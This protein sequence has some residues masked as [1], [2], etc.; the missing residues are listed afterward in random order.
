MFILFTRIFV[1]IGKFWNFLQF[2]CG[3]H[4]A[5]VWFLTLFNKQNQISA[6]QG[7]LNIS[8]KKR[9]FSKQEKHVSWINN[10]EYYFLSFYKVIG[11]YYDG[12][13][14]EYIAL[15]IFNLV[16]SSDL[17]FTFQCVINYPFIYENNRLNKSRSF[18]KS[19][20]M[21]K[22]HLKQ[23]FRKPKRYRIIQS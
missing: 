8:A 10:F 14:T 15:N 3:G 1:S 22:T 18:L 13:Y 5:W 17:A 4:F 21:S 16:Y 12:C 19:N 6:R 11:D 9:E 20:L 23:N 2:I 7:I